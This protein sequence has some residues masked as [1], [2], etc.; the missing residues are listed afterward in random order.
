MPKIRT[1]K[2]GGGGVTDSAVAT[3]VTSGTAT[4]A[5]LGSAYGWG[6]S[7]ARDLSGGTTT[8][9]KP[10]IDAAVTAGYKHIKVPRTAAALPSLST[11]TLNGIWLEFEDGA[12]I[13]HNHNGAAYDL[14]NCRL[15]N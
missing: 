12:Q 5:A 4:Q 7:L 6:Y 3:Q 14:T 11:I 10:L 1:S 9:I 2:P 8:D 15:T 13:S